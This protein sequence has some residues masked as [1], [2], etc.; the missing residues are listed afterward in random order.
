L[1]LADL[2]AS[3]SCQRDFALAQGFNT[4]IH[5]TRTQTIMEGARHCDFRFQL[6]EQTG[7]GVDDGHVPDI[8]EKTRGGRD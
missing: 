6:G 8:H 7:Q 1:G 3:L 2:G 5:L 4:A